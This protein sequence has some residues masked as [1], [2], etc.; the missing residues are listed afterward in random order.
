M[1]REEWKKTAVR[2]G[3]FLKQ[4]K[5]NDHPSLQHWIDMD[6]SD[7]AWV[8]PGCGSFME[9]SKDGTVYVDVGR[10]SRR[11]ENFDD[12]ADWLWKEWAWEYNTGNEGENFQ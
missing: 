11:F 9:M 10:E 3:D 4:D 2:L 6:L 7:N 12:A 8:F 5:A 1:T